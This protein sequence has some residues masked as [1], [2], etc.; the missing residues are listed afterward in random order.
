[1]AKK[2][3]HTYFG[4]STELDNLQK[5]VLKKTEIPQFSNLY[6]RISDLVRMTGELS[7]HQGFMVND[8][9]NSQFKYQREQGRTSFQEAFLLVQGS[10]FK[11]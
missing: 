10:E 9:L 2:L 6:Q 5:L 7:I 1:M 4:L 3:S 11:F 8:S